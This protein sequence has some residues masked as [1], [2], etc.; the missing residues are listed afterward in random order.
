[1]LLEA[2]VVDI[3]ATEEEQAAAV[4]VVCFTM[5][6]KH[7]KHRMELLLQFY[8]VWHMQSQL[9]RVVFLNRQHKLAM[10]WIHPS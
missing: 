4:L 3:T 10:A 9:E 5:V 8:L 1:L 7:L 2:V 6:L